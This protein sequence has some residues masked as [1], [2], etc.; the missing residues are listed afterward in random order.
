[1]KQFFLQRPFFRLLTPLVLGTIAYLLILLVNN[2]VLQLQAYFL[3]EELY[4]CLGLALV[5]Q[6][7]TWLSL[8]RLRRL[9]WEEGIVWAVLTRVLLS[10]LLVITVVGI[11]VWA[12]YIQVLGFRPSFRD[13][14]MFSGVFS[15]LAGLIISMQVSH[16]L[17]SLDNQMALA[18]EEALKEHIVADFNQF[19]QGINPDLLFE[20]LETLIVFLYTDKDQA[21]ELLDHLATVY[22]YVLSSRK[23]ELVP[24]GEELVVLQNLLELFG[25][26]PYRK[27]DWTATVNE[28]GYVIPGTLLHLVELV[29]RT[30]IV[31]ESHDL[32]LRLEEEEG[33]YLLSY[34]V[35]ERLQNRLN[36]S[37]LQQIRERY[38]IYTETP[39]TMSEEN[40]H[41]QIRIPILAIERS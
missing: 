12:Y 4:F 5:V 17:L 20:S 39:L 15:F 37:R 10:L 40:G 38:T 26:L 11:I 21:D 27:I 32:P 1:M 16:R 3:G 29:L 18:N 28:T 8:R 9:Q 30:S 14:L 33:C 31:M 2:N 35:L 25:R 22:R 7:L 19:K 41:K 36:N 34:P 13:L 6:E 24:I 23:Q